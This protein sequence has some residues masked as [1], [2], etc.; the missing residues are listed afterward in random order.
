[1]PWLLSILSA[2]LTLWLGLGW[3]VWFAHPTGAMFAWMI[4]LPALTWLGMAF[5]RLLIGR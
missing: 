1:M 4:I 5:M 2:A 3:L